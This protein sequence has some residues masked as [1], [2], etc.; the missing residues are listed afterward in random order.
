MGTAA[1]LP[2]AI[3][4]GGSDDPAVSTNSSI[5]PGAFAA[6]LFTAKPKVIHGI[7]Q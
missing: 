6:S 1:D 5:Y 7:V 4:A 2:T 3:I